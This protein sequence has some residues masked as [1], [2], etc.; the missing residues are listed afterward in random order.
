MFLPNVF[1]Q[2]NRSEI[3]GILFLAFNHTKESVSSN[4]VVRLLNKT[5]SKQGKREFS[6]K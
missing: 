4:H 5:V 1:N 3:Q 6:A 2:R